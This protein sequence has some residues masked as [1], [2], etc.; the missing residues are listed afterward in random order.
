MIRKENPEIILRQSNFRL[1]CE[2]ITV[3]WEVFLSQS[4]C[5]FQRFSGTTHFSS[6]NGE[7]VEKWFNSLKEEQIFSQ[8]DYEK[9]CFHDLGETMSEFEEGVKM[10]GGSRIDWDAEAP[11][12]SLLSREGG[13]S[14]SSLR[15]RTTFLVLGWKSHNFL[16]L[17]KMWPLNLNVQASF[18]RGI[19]FSNL[20]HVQSLFY[21]LRDQGLDHSNHDND[22]TPGYRPPEMDCI[23]L[24]MG[25][26]DSLQHTDI[27]H[28]ILLTLVP[29][30][31]VICK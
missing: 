27:L 18:L 25:A 7:D 12:Y 11:A 19:S 8:S 21:N 28:W 14:T 29:Q 26:S 2:T 4:S 3:S 30:C 6:S 15:N 16:Y 13:A 23:R 17:I 10:E 9:G 20:T 1:Q 24:P 5:L 22:H 31:A